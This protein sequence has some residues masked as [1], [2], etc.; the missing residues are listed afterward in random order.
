MT[1]PSKYRLPHNC[2]L[3]YSLENIQVIHIV[4][5]H[6]NGPSCLYVTDYTHNTMARPETASWCPITL[7]DKILQIAMWDSAKGEAT[8]METGCFY[9][10]KNV[11]IMAC[12]GKMNEDKK[13]K[14][15]DVD[16]LERHP[17]LVSLLRYSFDL[18]S[19]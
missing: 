17:H 19:R 7:K 9:S 10:L 16:E 6:G 14:K 1:A 8:Q 18:F 12:E 4:I 5:G 11:K 3:P 2:I 13:I 15:L